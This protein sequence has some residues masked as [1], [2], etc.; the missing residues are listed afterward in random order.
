M[1]KIEAIINEAIEFG[2]SYIGSY[3]EDFAAKTN[4]T[5]DKI[6]RYAREHGLSTEYKTYDNLDCWLVKVT[7]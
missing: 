6:E 4:K 1:K 3:A 7:K 5:F 2:A